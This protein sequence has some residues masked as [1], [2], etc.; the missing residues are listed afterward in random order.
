MLIYP[1]KL[2]WDSKW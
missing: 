1:M 2:I